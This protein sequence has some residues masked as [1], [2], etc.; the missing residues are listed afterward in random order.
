MIGTHNKQA[1]P[2]CTNTEVADE[3]LTPLEPEELQQLAIVAERVYAARR[4]RDRILPSCVLG[5]P[6]WDILLDLFQM[7]AQGR[8]VS[9]TSA[10]H[11]SGVPNTTALRS[12]G[13]LE[14]HGI[15]QR[16]PSETDRR[17]TL[18]SLTTL[19]ELQIAKILRLGHSLC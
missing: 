12:I 13:N 8:A 1:Y 6:G 16:L 18:V 2:D 15:V 19:G 7:K 14:K 10:C 5:E 3:E 11:A 4:L 9:V 17:R